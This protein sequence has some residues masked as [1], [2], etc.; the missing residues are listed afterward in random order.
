MMLEKIKA[1]VEFTYENVPL[2]RKLYREKPELRDMEGF[3]QLPYLTRGDFVLCGIEDSLSDVDEAIAILPPIRNQKLFP[4]PKLESADDRDS[5]Y[6][7]FYFLL[8]QAGVVDG[9]TFL[10]ITDTVHSY[11]CGEIASNLLYYGHPTWMM[12]L[13]DHSDEEIRSW[14]D[15]FE[16][17]YLLLGLD[18]MPKGILNWGVPSIFTI[19]QHNQDLSSSDGVLHFDI[20]AITEIG[21][22]A[23]RLPGGCYMYPTEYFYIETESGNDILTITVLESTLQPFIRYRTPDRGKVLGDGKLQVTYIGEH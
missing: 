1:L 7:I 5:R 2:Y 9:A 3:R 13:R 22:T 14:V 8:R 10:I 20:Y 18:R 16:P 11:Y 4:F 19:N 15:K 6:E 12:L 21:W 23:V 17:D